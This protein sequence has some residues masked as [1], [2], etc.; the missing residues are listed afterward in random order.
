MS[1]RFHRPSHALSWAAVFAGVFAQAGCLDSELAKRFREGYAP[2]AI[3]GLVAAA[4]NPWDEAGIRQALGA[5]A[6][7]V[8]S[9][10]NP[11]TSSDAAASN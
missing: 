4:A 8:G 2:G 3:E 7:G 1:R 6:E 5:L 10:I 11:R 9:V